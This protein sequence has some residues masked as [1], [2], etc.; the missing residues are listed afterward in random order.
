MSVTNNILL[1]QL[2]DGQTQLE[3]HLQN[4]SVWLT[5]VQMAELFDASH[6]NVTMHIRNV[7]KEGELEENAVGKESLLTAAD[8]KQNY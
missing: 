2:P 6:P 5:Q 1:Y 8:G 7:F 4:E 3:V